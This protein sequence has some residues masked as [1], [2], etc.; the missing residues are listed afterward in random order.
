MTDSSKSKNRCLHTYLKSLALA[1]VVVIALHIFWQVFLIG[2]GTQNIVTIDVAGRFNLDYELSVPTWLASFLAFNASVI[3][4]VIGYAQDNARRKMTWYLLAILAMFVSIDET[5][6]L[7]ELLLQ[8]V[9]L[10]AGFGQEQSYTAN[11]WLLVLPLILL[12]TSIL[13]RLIYKHI[14]RDTFMNIAVAGGVFL[15]GALVIEYASTEA[16]KTAAYYVLGLVVLEE[17]L[18]FF[19][20]WLA[21]RAM[22]I[23][24]AAHEKVLHQKI[25]NFCK[26]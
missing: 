17:G 20:I 6:A 4:A 24:I 15:L 2:S 7:H 8:A 21:I 18:E 10:G 3:A 1:I 9:H 22:G 13:L 12:A 11:A 23:H 5:A 26:T 16:D 19:G 25:L 14:P